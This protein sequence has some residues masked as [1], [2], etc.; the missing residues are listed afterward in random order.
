MVKTL[1][2]ASPNAVLYGLCTYQPQLMPFQLGLKRTRANGKIRLIANNAHGS[3][4]G[5]RLARG[6]ASRDQRANWPNPVIS[7]TLTFNGKVA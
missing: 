4:W 7:H 3:W 1:D 6:F 2:L 5:A